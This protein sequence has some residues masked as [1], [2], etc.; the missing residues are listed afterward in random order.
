MEHGL[1]GWIFLVVGLVFIF[2]NPKRLSEFGRGLGSF[3]REFRA[4]QREG[5]NAI[6]GAPARPVEPIAPARDE[7]AEKADKEAPAK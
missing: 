4:A 6:Q 3:M 2:G 1:F 5:E 7:A